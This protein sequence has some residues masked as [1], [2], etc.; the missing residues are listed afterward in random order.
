MGVFVIYCYEDGFVIV[1]YGVAIKFARVDA[2]A[3]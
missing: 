2:W 1:T 3:C